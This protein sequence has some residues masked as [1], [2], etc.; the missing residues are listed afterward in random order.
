MK[1]LSAKWKWFIFGSGVSCVLA[2][3]ATAHLMSSRLGQLGADPDLAP[4][5]IMIAGMVGMTFFG[6]VIPLAALVG[7]VIVIVD[8]YSRGRS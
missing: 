4:P 8:G 3:L 5:A 2:A 7:V 1:N 6:L